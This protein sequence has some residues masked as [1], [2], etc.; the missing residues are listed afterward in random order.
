MHRIAAPLGDALQVG[1]GA[2]GPAAALQDRHVQG[3]VGVEGLEGV[4][5][6]PG[7]RAVDGVARRRP[8]DGDDEGAAADSRC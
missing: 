2:E 8:L 3:L 5:E 6:L 7:G 4:V 1:A